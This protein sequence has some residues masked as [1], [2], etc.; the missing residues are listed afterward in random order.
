MGAVPLQAANR[1]RL[2]K[3]DTWRTSPMTVAAMTGP[4]PNSPVRLVPAARTAAA[5]FLRV[6]RIR[7]PA[8]RRS[9]VSSAASSQRAAS[10]APAGV[11]EARTRAAWPAVISPQTPPGTSPQHLVQ[12]AG[13]LGCAPG[14]GPG[15]AWPAP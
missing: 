15:S 7:V 5:A 4:A 14:P 11:L 8:P 9:S 10:A 2:P 3:R 1:S 12:P 13:H 6:S